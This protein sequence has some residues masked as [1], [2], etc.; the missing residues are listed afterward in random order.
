MLKFQKF[1]LLFE[2]IDDLLKGLLQDKNLLLQKRDFLLLVHA[3]LL[4]LLGSVILDDEVSILFLVLQIKLGLLSS[5]ILQGV[6]L[7][8]SLFRQLLVFSVNLPLNFLNVL[9][10]IILSL[11]FELLQSSLELDLHLLLHSS[12]RDLDTVL[13]L[14]DDLLQTFAILLHRLERQLISEFLFANRLKL[15]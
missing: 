7:G 9:L 15:V 2:V 5:V 11:L 6:P 12:L 10:S 8:H 14:L 3:S 4:V 13:L 1:F